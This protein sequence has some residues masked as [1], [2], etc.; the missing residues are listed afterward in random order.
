MVVKSLSLFDIYAKSFFPPLLYK[1]DILYINSM[2]AE[3][4]EAEFFVFVK[5]KKSKEP[6]VY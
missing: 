5:G 1:Q 3:L 4:F 2:L 6:K